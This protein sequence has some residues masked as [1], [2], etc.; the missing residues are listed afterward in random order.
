MPPRVFGAVDV[1][2][3]GGRVMAGVVE[4]GRVGVRCVHRFPNAPV[5]RDHH[6]HWDIET[7]FAEVLDGL[8]TLGQEHP[9]VESIGVDTWGVDYA[10]TRR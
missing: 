2:A 1:G 8:R 5:R 7:I 6:L 4:D 9:E 10:L 3:S